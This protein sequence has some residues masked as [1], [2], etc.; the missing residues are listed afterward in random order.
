VSI[1]VII[2]TANRAGSLALT[3][4]SLCRQSTK[5]GEFELVVVDN[6]LDDCTRK[7]VEGAIRD[8]PDHKIKYV[9][10]NVPGQRRGG[11]ENCRRVCG[12]GA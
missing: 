3:L 2:P 8:Y 4:A 12:R 7:A 11:R 6:A 5:A 9:Q 10:E 1:S